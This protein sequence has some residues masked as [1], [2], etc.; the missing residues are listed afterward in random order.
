MT[1]TKETTLM[2]TTI[3]KANDTLVTYIYNNEAVQGKEK[4]VRKLKIN[5][6]IIDA[7][8]YSCK[9]CFAKFG[10]TSILGL[11]KW[12]SIIDNCVENSSVEEF[13]IAGGEPMLHPNFMDIVKY[14]VEVKGKRCSLITN[15]V[16]MNEEWIKKNAKYFCMIGFSVDSFDEN[17]MDLIGRT[18]K[19][20]DKLTFDKFSSFTKCIKKSNPDCIIKVNTVVTSI[21]YTDG[22]ANRMEMLPVDKWKVLKMRVFSKG[23]FDNS[24]I[25][26]SN[27]EF[28]TF[29]EMNLGQ[30]SENSNMSQKLKFHE[31]DIVIEK[32]T[33]SAYVLVDSNGDLVDNTNSSNYKAIGSCMEM[34]FGELFAQLQL[35]EG[36]YASRY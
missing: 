16:L 5:L 29:C 33:E 17:L 13:N 4:T 2:N 22:I 36:L 35:D 31:M 8:N 18:T 10:S 23:D 32:D 21:N 28:D 26:I 34:N 15:G 14:I 20:G 6:H 25:A 1:I 9:H 30:K 19:K 7:C 27:T 12:K 11:E 24:D 3:C